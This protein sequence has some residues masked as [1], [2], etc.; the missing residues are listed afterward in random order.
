V[1]E[2]AQ[3]E[4]AATDPAPATAPA[5]TVSPAEAYAASIR[6]IGQVAIPEDL[7]E[8]LELAARDGSM[9]NM[10]QHSAALTQRLRKQS[11]TTAKGGV[12][13]VPVL[14]PATG[15]RNRLP[16]RSE[17][18]KLRIKELENLDSDA[19]EEAFER[20]EAMGVLKPKQRRMMVLEAIASPAS[21]APKYIDKE[22]A[23]Y[24]AN[25]L[26]STY[27]AAFRVLSELRDVA[28]DF[29][30]A[31]IL[32]YGAGPGTATWA[33]WDVWGGAIKKTVAV[34]PSE[35]MMVLGE[36]LT[37][38]RQIAAEERQIG[39]PRVQWL[40]KIPGFQ[41]HLTANLGQKASKRPRALGKHDMV[42]ASYVLTELEG[43]K[44][45][46]AMVK[47]LWDLTSDVLVLI[48]PGTPVGSANCREA[49]AKLLGIGD[50][51]IDNYSRGEAHVLLPC[52]HDGR[53]PLDGTKHW[54]HFVQRHERTRAQR[55]VKA[56]ASRSRPRG[57]QDEKF[58]FVVIRRGPRPSMAPPV[59]LGLLQPLHNAAERSRGTEVPPK[60][61]VDWDDLE[62]GTREL[63]LSALLE[64]EE[65]DKDGSLKARLEQQLR[66]EM[67]GKKGPSA[68]PPEL[69]PASGS[70]SRSGSGDEHLTDEQQETEDA[71]LPV[72]SE[73][74]PHEPQEEEDSDSED[75]LA[76]SPEGLQAALSD[77]GL[78]SRIIRQP[79][80][81]RK[82][83]VM[84]M[85]SPVP[86][87]SGGGRM[88]QIT[89][90]KSFNK[91]FRSPGPYYCARRVQWGDAWPMSYRKP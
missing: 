7:S 4:G 18:K 13:E 90:S 75:E 23:A 54:C 91:K 53:C 47:A 45:R 44:E 83:V 21:V 77:G 49:R 61:E 27:S 50:S 39:F 69:G 84:T 40:H 74:L 68:D 66:E 25:R 38:A 62:E 16:R 51:S 72:V 80:K 28:P 35:A 73:A 58:S 89:I 34:E 14:E 1:H 29:S 42:I 71:T 55:Q 65:E 88:E 87:N 5:Q 2:L 57:Y 6:H 22:V 59:D 37:T 52:T 78:W 10:R 3:A 46:L 79:L 19:I 20:D 48:E 36:S 81:R 11:R 70:A 82:H 60:P 33:A 12:S 85:C 30:P 86:G 8:A 24:A 9:K 76:V 67:G 32:D 63:L 17:M 26:P 64:G 15:L 56:T 41:A 43:P 31:T